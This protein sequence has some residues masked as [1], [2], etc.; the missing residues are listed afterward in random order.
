MS[1]LIRKHWR[2]IVLL[3]LALLWLSPLLWIVVTSLKTRTEVF[4]PASGILPQAA[5]WTN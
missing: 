5:Q 1:T 4:D 3:P 2:H